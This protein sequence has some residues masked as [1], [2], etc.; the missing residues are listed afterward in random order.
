MRP[1]PPSSLF[2]DI[3]SPAFAPAGDMP[4]WV[5]ATFLDPAS[6]VHNP[7]HLHL[8]FADIGYL[9]TAVGNSKKG[10]RVIGQCET[11]SPQGTMGKWSRARAE[12][13]VKQWFGHVPDFII[14]L[15][16]DYC[17]ECG[18]AEFMAL[19]EHELYHAAQDVDAF[20][21]PKFSKS[22]GRPVFVIRGHD[23]EEFVGVVRRYGAD[24]AGVR[25]MVDAANRPAEISAIT[26]GHLC[27]SCLARV[28]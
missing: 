3:T 21:A 18:D 23:V 28:A 26:I 19:V 24:A 27:G 4:D 8:S 25:A 17:R 10:R 6:P 22:T 5:D 11:G 14:T 9:W 15:D 7:D 13:Q 1:Q 2:D 12:M 20:G 16:A